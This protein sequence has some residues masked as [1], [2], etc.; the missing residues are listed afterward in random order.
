MWAQYDSSTDGEDNISFLVLIPKDWHKEKLSSRNWLFAPRN[1]LEAGHFPEQLTVTCHTLDWS[2]IL[3]KYGITGSWNS[4]YYRSGTTG[5]KQIDGPGK[6]GILFSQDIRFHVEDY[7]GQD[8]SHT[9][10]ALIQH[11]NSAVEI[12]GPQNLKDEF[13]KAVSSFK[14]ISKAR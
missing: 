10:V 12:R 1:Y 4:G 5:P 6:K 11:N 3:D 2:R 8:V 14:I 7:T 13:E 9:L